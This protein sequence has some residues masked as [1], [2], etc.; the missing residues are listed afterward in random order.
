LALSE[1]GHAGVTSTDHGVAVAKFYRRLGLRFC[2]PS[3][4]LSPSLFSFSKLCK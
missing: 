1:S 3:G 4:T 2:C